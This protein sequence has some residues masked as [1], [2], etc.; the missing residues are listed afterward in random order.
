[1]NTLFATFSEH[2][3]HE[4]AT[5]LAMPNG[6]GKIEQTEPEPRQDPSTAAQDDEYG[7]TEIESLCMN[8]HD[9]V[10]FSLLT[11]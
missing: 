4:M 8:C 9:N 5:D 10:S 2:T 11:I 6:T 3:I 7:V 1:M